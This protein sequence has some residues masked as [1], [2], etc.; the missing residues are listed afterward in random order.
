MKILPNLS[1]RVMGIG[2]RLPP[3]SWCCLGM[4]IGVLV[5]GFLGLTYFRTG[6]ELRLDHRDAAFFVPIGWQSR[7][8]SNFSHW[9][10]RYSI[11]SRLTRIDSQPYGTQNTMAAIPNSPTMRSLFISRSR[12]SRF[13]GIPRLRCGSAETAAGRG[14]SRP[15][16]PVPML[17]IALDGPVEPLWGSR[18]AG[19]HISSPHRRKPLR[20]RLRRS[21]RANL[22]GRRI[23]Y[24]RHRPWLDSRKG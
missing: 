2:F 21:N 24:R 4:P 8:D 5:D 11:W 6:L 22:P 16:P 23:R 7:S 3:S 19:R 12:W 14:P 1:D 15:D 17:R 10:S 20:R 18:T 13:P 9:S